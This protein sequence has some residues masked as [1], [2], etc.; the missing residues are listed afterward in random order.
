MGQCCCK[1]KTVDALVYADLVAALDAYRG[2]T[3]TVALVDNQGEVL[4]L[5]RHPK[6][7][8][9]APLLLSLVPAVLRASAVLAVAL[10]STPSHATSMALNGADWRCLL[11]RLPMSNATVVLLSD[12]AGRVAGN[13]ALEQQQ[14]AAIDSCTVALERDIALATAAHLRT[15]GT[16]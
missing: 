7:G 11:S 8:D 13:E 14:L 10:G 15:R 5:R 9:S 3:G 12:C 4:A 16:E 6:S 2:H 1:V